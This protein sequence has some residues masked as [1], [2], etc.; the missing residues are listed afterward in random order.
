M[1]SY[2]LY[3]EEDKKIFLQILTSINQSYYSLPGRYQD[4]AFEQAEQQFKLFK[5]KFPKQIVEDDEDE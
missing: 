1:I 2:K 4:W 3:E 5:K